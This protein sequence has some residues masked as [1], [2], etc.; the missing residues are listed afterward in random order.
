MM[1]PMGAMR[2]PFSANQPSNRYGN[3]NPFAGRIPN[4]LNDLRK[5]VRDRM[6]LKPQKPPPP[7]PQGNPFLARR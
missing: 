5:R 3:K 1:N 7:P 2:P 4:M 6:G